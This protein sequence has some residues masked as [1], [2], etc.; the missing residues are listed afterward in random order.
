MQNLSRLHVI[1]GIFPQVQ[2]TSLQ[3]DVDGFIQKCCLHF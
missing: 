3:S 1:L 2:L